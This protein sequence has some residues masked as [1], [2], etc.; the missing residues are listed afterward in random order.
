MRMNIQPVSV[1]THYHAHIYFEGAEQRAIAEEVR[2]AI[3]ARFSVQLGR[4]HDRLVGPHARPMYQVAFGAKLFASLVPWL[5]LNRQDLAVL[6]HPET[7]NARRDHLIHALWL[8]EI[9]PIMN[10]EQLP[11]VNEDEA[12]AVIVPNTSPGLVP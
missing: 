5:M 3:A 4:W 6:V 9:L 7:G 1:I 12:D 8:G 10:P 11:E 2:A